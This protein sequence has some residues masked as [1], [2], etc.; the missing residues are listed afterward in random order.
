MKRI[1]EPD[2][3]T[4]AAGLVTVDHSGRM[5]QINPAAAE[6]LGFPLTWL[7]DKPF[8]VFVPPPHVQ[9]ILTYFANPSRFG[10]KTSFD[11]HV[12]TDGR[13]RLLRTSIE[14]VEGKGNYVHRI[15]LVDLTES[16]RIE[17]FA[18]LSV[19]MQ[20][21]PDVI[22]T[23]QRTGEIVFVSR[24][25]WGYSAAEMI[26]RKIYDYLSPLDRSNF[27]QCLNSVFVT[28]APVSCEVSDENAW[29]RFSFGSIHRRG[30]GG[31]RTTSVVIREVSEEKRAEDTLRASNEQIRQFSARLE[32]VREEERTRLAREIHDEL[33][34]ALTGLRLDLSWLKSKTPRG[35]AR[36]KLAEMV[37]HVDE[38]IQTVRRIAS[39][40]RP[41][42]LD[43]LG[44]VPA[45]EWQIAEF[46]KRT[47]IDC[48]FRSRV[49][50]ELAKELST[51]VFRIVQE[52]LT[53]VMRHANAS[54]VRVRLEADQAEL[55]LFI[56]DNGR[57]FS[58]I[59]PNGKTSLGLLGM[60][61]RVSRFGGEIKIQSKPGQG[62]RL[63]IV[64][65]L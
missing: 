46:Q 7:I 26:G 5:R 64:L 58:E 31:A 25:L 52:A 22:M 6:L 20:T 44:L 8:I 54:V 53:N 1:A 35:V 11:S 51:A 21:V 48:K 19:A 18:N 49:R 23:L 61:E 63:A 33:G 30:A 14:T 17:S 60:K 41:A 55:K 36:R 2:E 56:S 50:V 42:V 65:P 37:E 32:A 28:G 43:D 24:P 27:H 13:D 39:E 38:V 4:N 16:Q 9:Q 45:I 62:T 40:L 12:R 15:T 34:Q 59:H 10:F 29:Y 57:G 47:R 3:R